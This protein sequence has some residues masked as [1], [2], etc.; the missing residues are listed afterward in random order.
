[1]IG[2]LAAH[3]DIS[4]IKIGL[5]SSGTPRG[6]HEVGLIAVNHLDSSHGSIHLANATFLQHYSVGTH[7]AHHK[8][9]GVV[10]LRATV[11]KE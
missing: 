10:T 5:G 9:L 7:L 1:M 2:A 6:Y 3:H 8:T 11:V 4:G